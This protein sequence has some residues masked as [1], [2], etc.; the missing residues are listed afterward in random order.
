MLRSIAMAKRASSE[1]PASNSFHSPNRKSPV[2]LG[3]Q[4]ADTLQ[5]LE[6]RGLPFFPTVLCKYELVA[7]IDLAKIMYEQ[8]RHHAANVDLQL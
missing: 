3:A 5:S 1:A 6:F 2:V 7:A 4:A 8:Q